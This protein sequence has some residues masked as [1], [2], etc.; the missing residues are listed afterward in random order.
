M[1]YAYAGFIPFF[2]ALTFLTCIIPWF[3]FVAPL[4]FTELSLSSVHYSKVAGTEPTLKNPRAQELWEKWSHVW[5]L[6]WDRQQ[7]LQNKYN[8]L[9]EVERLKNFSFE[10]WRKRVSG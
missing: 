10:E 1:F 8:H 9:Q 6:S 5:M 7:R 2:S 3:N 4:P